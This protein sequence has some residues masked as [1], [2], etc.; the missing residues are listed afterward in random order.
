MR[1]AYL[2]LAHARPLQLGRLVQTLQDDDNADIYIHIDRKSHLEPFL[3]VHPPSQQVFY[4][5]HRIEVNW[6]GFSIVRATLHLLREAVQ[7]GKYDYYVLLS[8]ADY[9][10][11]PADELRSKLGKEQGEYID[12]HPMPWRKR[13]MHLDRLRCFFI[14]ARDRHHVG[15]KLT[16]K[17]L[18]LLPVRPYESALHPLHPY[19]GSQWWTLSRECAE[20]VLDFVYSH[21]RFVRFFRFARFSDETFFHTIVA[22]SPFAAR[23]RDS[24]TFDDWFEKVPPY[25]A[26]L[27]SS[28]LTRLQKSDKFFARKFSLN[29]DPLVFSRIDQ[30]LLAT[31]PME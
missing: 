27:D 28:D 9:P 2:I 25:P 18:Q 5:S 23:V 29:Q 21:K 30:E 1:I 31:S 17:V 8:G 3:R 24:L 13:R 11:K 7:Q 16:N 4:L 20:Y 14:A 22:A 19:C 12:L 15:V 6:A 26:L 10:I